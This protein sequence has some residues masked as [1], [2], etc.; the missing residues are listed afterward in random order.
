MKEKIE[1]LSIIKEY[2][3]DN[4]VKISGDLDKETEK[5]KN[6]HVFSYIIQ[7]FNNKLE[8]RK[9][10]LNHLLN[11]VLNEIKKIKNP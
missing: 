3:L 5:A 2:L 8:E 11:E 9:E 1:E 6:A 10:F 4:I 7:I